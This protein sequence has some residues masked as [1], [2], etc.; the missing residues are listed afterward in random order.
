MNFQ[1]FM[2]FD[3][4]HYIGTLSQPKGKLGEVVARVGGYDNVFSVEFGD[5]TYIVSGSSLRRH[6]PSPKDEVEVHVRR[7][8]RD[9]EE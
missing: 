7:R 5:D 6:V 1:N 3:K 4:V 2:P 8:R 9:D